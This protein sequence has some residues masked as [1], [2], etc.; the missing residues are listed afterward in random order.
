MSKEFLQDR[1]FKH[2]NKISIDI[3]TE[4]SREFYVLLVNADSSFKEKMEC[5]MNLVNQLAQELSKKVTKKD[6]NFITEDDIDETLGVTLREL[7]QVLVY[8]S[9]S[10]S[11]REGEKGFQDF[12]KLEVGRR[13]KRIANVLLPKGE[14]E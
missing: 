8:I 12:D 2:D 7:S 6:G 14:E 3:E 11:W 4:D 10:Y 13:L 9:N 5:S 1:V